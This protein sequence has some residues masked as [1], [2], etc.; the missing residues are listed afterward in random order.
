MHGISHI[1]D[2]PDSR[3]SMGSSDSPSG[4][5]HDDP[6]W[7]FPAFRFVLG[8]QG[9]RVSLVNYGGLLWDIHGY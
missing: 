1:L 3:P 8:G 2:G 9:P 5:I 4:I 6:S 7:S